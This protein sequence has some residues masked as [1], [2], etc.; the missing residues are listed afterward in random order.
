MLN[1]KQLAKIKKTLSQS[2]IGDID[3]MDNEQLK[4]RLFMCDVNIKETREFLDNNQ[5]VISLKE[6][7]K[8]IVGP[9]KDAM[10]HQN[11]IKDYAMHRLEE[12]GAL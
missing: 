11:C 9:S 10:K 3:S 4:E 8:E 5:R 6:E 1:E 7:L 12:R 2:I